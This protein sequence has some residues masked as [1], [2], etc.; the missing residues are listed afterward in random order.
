M[1][2]PDLDIEEIFQSDYLSAELLVEKKGLDK[3][4]KLVIRGVLMEDVWNPRTKTEEL[5]PVIEFVGTDK[6]LVVIKTNAMILSDLFGPKTLDWKDRTIKLYATMVKAFGK[7]QPGIRV[8]HWTQEDGQAVG[9]ES[10]QDNVAEETELDQEETE[11]DQEE[12]REDLFSW[13]GKVYTSDALVEAV[14]QVQRLPKRYKDVDQQAFLVAADKWLNDVGGK[15][16]TEK[17]LPF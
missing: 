13:R 14:K 7:L 1:Q 4:Q 15:E 11:L 3:D 8:R 9:A 16:F 6:K 2:Y 12:T 5:K 10:L 17:D